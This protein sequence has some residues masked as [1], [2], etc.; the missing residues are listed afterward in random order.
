MADIY[1]SADHLVDKPPLHTMKILFW[2]AV[3]FR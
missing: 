1:T 2:A 3:R